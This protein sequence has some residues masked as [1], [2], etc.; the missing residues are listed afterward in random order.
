MRIERPRDRRT[1]KHRDEFAPFIQSP[2][3]AAKQSGIVRLRVLAVFM[4][5]INSTFVS[6][7]TGRLAGF[8]PLEY[9]L[10]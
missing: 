3:G 1:A 6:C 2:V 8:S 9:P 4:L 10:V 5:M 7:W